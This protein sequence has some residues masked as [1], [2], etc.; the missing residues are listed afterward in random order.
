[1]EEYQKQM[2]LLNQQLLRMI[3]NY[4]N[5]SEEEEAKWSKWI[6]STMESTA[7][8]LNSYPRCPEPNRAMGLAPHTDTSLITLVHQTQISG[9]QIHKD[10]PGW[11]PVHP[12][13]GAFVV[14][15]GD[16]LHILS[17]GRFT[18]VLHRATVNQTRQRFSVA[19]FYSPPADFTVS[20]LL[21]SSSSSGLG[22]EQVARYRSVT[23]K[24]YAGLKAKHHLK[25]LSLVKINN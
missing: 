16:L 22:G 8:Q 2:K 7:L 17:N 1:M 11:V 15:V 5:I 20:P 9:L 23:V 25:A 14:N 12:I 24:E 21:W 13:S 3:L 19:F 4:L 6:G 18:N 10:G